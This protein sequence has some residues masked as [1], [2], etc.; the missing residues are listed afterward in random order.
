[1]TGL[2][3]IAMQYGPVPENWGKIY[4]SLKDIE[5][6]ECILPNQ[7]SGIRLESTACSNSTTLTE[8]ELMVLKDVC[9]RFSEMNVRDISTESYREKGW[10]EN[11]PAKSHIDYVYAFDLS[12]R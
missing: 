1:M 8:E 3:Y 6:N 12:M 2:K 5:M 7:T 9:P 4:D 11:S 10:I